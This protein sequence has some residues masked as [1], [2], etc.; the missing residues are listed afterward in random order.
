MI[1]WFAIIAFIVSVS[2]G[3]PG[4]AT[5]STPPSPTPTTASVIIAHMVERNPSLASYRSRIHV[6]VRMLNFPYLAPKLDGTSYFLRPNNYEV[7]FDRVP[8]YAAGFSRLFS[9]I[10]DAGTWQKENDVSY[11]GMRS[12][13]GHPMMILRLT[14]KI[15]ST[16]LDH[17]TAYVDPQSFELVEMR[18]HYT[19]GGTITMQQ[20]YRQE[21]GYTVLAAQHAVIDIPH[22]HAIADSKYAPYQTNVAIASTVFQKP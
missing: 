20:Q 17:T 2:W 7:V 11:E 13:R 18:W 21:G 6:D 15:H 12:L 8:H 9:D 3:I 1:R 4:F 19:S 5:L 10:G 16:I 22:V 14:K